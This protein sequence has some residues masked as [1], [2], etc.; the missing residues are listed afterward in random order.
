MITKH[1]YS[2][3]LRDMI[4]IMEKDKY[5]KRSALLFKILNQSS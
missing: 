3:N 4:F 1:K 5:L 2:A